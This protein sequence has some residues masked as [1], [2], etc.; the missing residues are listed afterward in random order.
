MKTYDIYEDGDI[1]FKNLFNIIYSQITNIIL[2]S[3]VFGAIFFGF[4]Y[5]QNDKFTSKIVIT[6]RSESSAG[7]MQ[8]GLSSL[9]QLAGIELGSGATPKEEQSYAILLSRVNLLGFI[10]SSES[11]KSYFL[12]Q[13]KTDGLLKFDTIFEFINES[14]SM[15]R[16]KNTGITNIYFSAFDQEI[17]SNFLNQLIFYTNNSLKKE[18]QHSSEQKVEFLTIESSKNSYRNVQAIFGRM[19][20]TEIQRKMIANT[21][22]EFAFQVIDPATTPSSKSSP[23]ILLSLFLGLIIGFIIGIVVAILRKTKV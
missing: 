3:A 19:I 20:E 7:S 4:A 13:T 16:S 6:Y 17:V 22:K 10:E 1:S 12:E 8:S 11:F 14:L 9:G 23:R 5:S 21:E 15:S 2:T 18:A